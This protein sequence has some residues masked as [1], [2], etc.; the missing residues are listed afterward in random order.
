MLRPLLSLSQRTALFNIADNI[1]EQ[2]LVRNYTLTASDLVQIQ[3]QREEHNR[4]GYAVQMAYLRFPGR[5]MQ[6]GES[7]PYSL[8][9][10]LAAQLHLSP[11]VFTLYAKRDTTRREHAVRIQKYL[12]LRSLTVQYEHTFRKLLLP[13]AVQTGSNIAVVT[14]LL[15]EMRARKIIIPAMSTVEKVAYSIQEEARRLLFAEL[16]ANITNAQRER[17]DQLLALRDTIQT[18]LVWL[19]NYPRRPTPQG[20]LSAIE[21]IEYIDALGLPARSSNLYENRIS[22]LAREGIRHTPQYIER[23]DATRRYGLLVAIISELRKD[24]IDHMITMHD[25]M[26]GQFFTRS[27]RQ[28]KEAFHKRGKQ[29]NEKV[30]LYAKVGTALIQAKDTNTDWQ[31]ALASVISWDHFR[32]SVAEAEAL[33][34]GENF[35]FLDRLKTRYSY[36]R[37]YVPKLLSTLQTHATPAAQPLLTAIEL[38]KELNAT[39]K[40]TIPATAPTE[41]IKERWEGYIFEGGKID[42][43][44]YE[45]HVLSELRNQFRSGDLWVEGSRAHKEFDSYILPHSEWERLCARGQTGLAVTTDWQTYITDRKA[46]LHKRLTEVGKQ[47]ARG[48]L[49]EVTLTDD[50]LH[51]GQPEKTVPDAAITLAQHA[52]SLVPPIKLTDLLV[53]VDSWTHFSDYF[54]RDDDATKVVKEKEVLFAAIL[55]DATNLG[56]RKMAQVS[57]GITLNQLAWMSDYYI[58]EET[59]QKALSE[60]INFH[61]H[62]PFSWYWG[63]GKTASSDGQHFPIYSRKGHTTQTNAKYGNSPSAMFYTHIS[64]QYSPFYTQPIIATARDATYVIDGLLY[65]QSDLNIEEIY[66]DTAGFTDHVFALCHLLG[67][68]FEPRIRD[69]PDK[70][71]Y[72]IEHPSTYKALFPIIGSRINLRSLEKNY[73]EVLRL[74]CS[75]KSGTVTAS[76]MLRKLAAQHNSLSSALREL[77]RIERTLFMLD[78]LEQPHLR[79]QVLMGLNKGEARNALAKAVFFYRRGE[80]VDRTWEEQHNSASGLNLVVAAII[81]WNTVYL[82][83]AIAHLKQQGEVI[84][85]EYLKHLSPVA[86]EHISLTGDYVWNLKQVTTLDTLRSLRNV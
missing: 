1:S 29:I 79:L 46:L 8:L 42:R 83:K 28:Q 32:T 66:T 6:P 34:M 11:R 52:Y 23:L 12:K 63:E 39:G 14:A 20:V 15:E 77:G 33:A 71:L 26:I 38:L 75:I 37:Q 53:E 80:V 3:L 78:Y 5:P 58:R 64:D 10:Y 16:T 72:T 22:R 85:E 7:I 76:L 9:A 82:A 51:I 55:A 49:P 74:A 24:I 56:L 69:L 13:K 61:H 84:I 4:L 68:H 62:F 54:T 59:Y 2:E 48:S 65:H 50:V 81:L 47:I 70:K 35:D 57:P 21:R 19:K 18:N 17:L 40:R 67:K 31:K 25:K 44:Y 60:I 43:Q 45:L 27:E 36:L 30:H 86:W 73:T 41:F